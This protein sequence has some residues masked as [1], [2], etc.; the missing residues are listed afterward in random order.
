[1][2]TRRLKLS[3]LRE[4]YVDRQRPLPRELERR[5]REDDRL[6]AGRILAAI[7]KRRRDNRAEGQR[8]R[9]ML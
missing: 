4:R 6:G 3:D 9:Q 1:M 8:L 5:L 7:E 2:T